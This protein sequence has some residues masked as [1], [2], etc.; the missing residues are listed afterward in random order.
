MVRCDGLGE[1]RGSAAERS[2]ACHAS[3]PMAVPFGR[4]GR[5]AEAAPAAAY[6][7]QPDHDPAGSAYPSSV[8]NRLLFRVH[9]QSGSLE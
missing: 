1:R 3:S 4:A 7:A 8:L 9:S 5:Q 6:G 2:L